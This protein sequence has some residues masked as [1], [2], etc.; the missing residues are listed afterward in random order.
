AP[1]GR[2]VSVFGARAQPR[3]QRSEMAAALEWTGEASSGRLPAGSKYPDAGQISTLSVHRGEGVVSRKRSAN[4]WL[5]LHRCCEQMKH[6]NAL[7]YAVIP[8]VAHHK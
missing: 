3:S 5:S 7:I 8:S 1:A 4:A 2:A 6:R